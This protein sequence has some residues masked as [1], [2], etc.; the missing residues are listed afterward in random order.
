MVVYII[1]FVKLNEILV[2]GVQEDGGKG[3]DE[4][5][6]RRMLFQKNN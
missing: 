5:E 2:K 1:I 6:F 3:D 4:K